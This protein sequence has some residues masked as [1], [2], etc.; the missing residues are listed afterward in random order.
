MGNIQAESSAH[1]TS[2]MLLAFYLFPSHSHVNLLNTTSNNCNSK[3]I[4]KDARENG[5]GYGDTKDRR[6][7]GTFCRFTTVMQCCL[8]M[9][10]EFSSQWKLSTVIYT[11]CTDR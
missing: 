6:S 2:L 11:C 7:H 9:T 4:L 3:V 10:I 1:S 5:N 8:K